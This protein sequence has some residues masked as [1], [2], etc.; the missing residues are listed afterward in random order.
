MRIS[1]LSR[2]TGV[3]VA[4]IK[5]YL[6]E[7]LLPPGDDAGALN[8][9][10]Y[11]ERHVHRLHLVR[12]LLRVGGLSVAAARD[13]VHA[14]DDPAVN[15]H[16][17]IGT[18]HTALPARGREPIEAPPDD[19]ATARS[20][21][22][23]FLAGLGWPDAATDMSPPMWVLAEALTALRRLGGDVGPEVFTLYAET[24]DVL[25]GQELSTIDPA[26]GGERMIEDVVIGT[27]VF[28]SALVALR[29]L[30]HAKHSAARFGS[31]TPPDG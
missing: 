24:A 27:V 17:L 8:Q 2:T 5:Y 25:A 20:E 1:E 30:A 16:H 4:T 10:E 28:E 31:M 29:R 6:R 11:T 26:R 15:W 12:T 23:N 21:V 7:G 18:A 13:T 22:A 3:S 9:A 19:V 14:V